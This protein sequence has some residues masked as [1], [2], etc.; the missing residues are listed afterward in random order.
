[1][2]RLYRARMPLSPAQRRK[3]RSLAHPLKPVVMLGQAGLTPAVIQEADNALEH[4]ELIKVRIA[5]GDRDEL[6]RRLADIARETKA[7]LVQSIG[8]IGVFY[9]RHPHKPKLDIGP[10]E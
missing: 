5:A 3:L 1:M 4:H 10:R 8:H 7:E 9:R 2:G 6:R